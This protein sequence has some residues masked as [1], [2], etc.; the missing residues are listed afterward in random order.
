MSEVPLG[1]TALTVRLGFF[2]PKNFSQS[3]ISHFPVLFGT[4]CTIGRGNG[5]LLWV[6]QSHVA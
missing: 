1:D 2:K 6:A 4:I 5:N 3:R